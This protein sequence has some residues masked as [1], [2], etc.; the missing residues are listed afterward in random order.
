MPNGICYNASRQNDASVHGGTAK[1]PGVVT[2]GVFLFRFGKVA[3]ALGWL[4]V[5]RP[6]P[7]IC[8]HSRQLCLPQRREEMMRV[9]PTLFIFLF[10]ASRQGV[11][12]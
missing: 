2:S 11:D 8:K 9:Y 7:T 5:T 1:N 4:P 12:F 6:R 3:Y 10:Y